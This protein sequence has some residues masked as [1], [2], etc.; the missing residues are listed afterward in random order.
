MPTRCKLPKQMPICNV[1][2]NEPKRTWLHASKKSNVTKQS[3]NRIA[4]LAKDQQTARNEIVEAAK[5]LAKA[6]MENAASE[7][8]TWS[9]RST[10]GWS[11]NGPSGQPMNGKPMQG[12]AAN[13]GSTF[14]CS[15]TSAQKLAN[16]EAKFADAQTATGQGA[17]QVSG[18]EQVANQPLKE[19]LEIA[20]GLPQGEQPMGDAAGQP[21]GQQGQMGMA[22]GQANGQQGQMGMGMGMGMGQGQPMGQGMGMGMG[23]GQPMGQG[24]G[25]GKDKDK[26]RGNHLELVRSTNSTSNCLGHRWS[27]S[28]STRSTNCRR[29]CSSTRSRNVPRY[30]SR[31]GYGYGYGYGTTTW[32]GDGNG[33][34]SANASSSKVAVPSPAHHHRT[35]KSHPET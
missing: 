25:M 5:E 31:Y 19:A 32:H 24:M 1:R 35:A 9:R 13:D 21:M 26:H 18:Q 11:T 2:S 17:E 34:G 29:C 33:H 4:Q 7:A 20:S 28:T 16:A 14:C 23:Q 6:A 10:Y 3:L 27:T 15:T 30:G 8:Q 22:E 12:Q